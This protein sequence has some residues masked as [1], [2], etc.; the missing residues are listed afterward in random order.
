MSIGAGENSILH[1]LHTMAAMLVESYITYTVLLSV[2]LAVQST[3]SM[4]IPGIDA[5]IETV[6][7]GPLFTFETLLNAWL[8]IDHIIFNIISLEDKAQPLM[9]TAAKNLHIDD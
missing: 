5:L 7:I 9:M 2:L 3:A 4:P 6:M 8:I 1:A